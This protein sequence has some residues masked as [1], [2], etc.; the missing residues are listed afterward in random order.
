MTLNATSTV[1]ATVCATSTVCV[2]VNGG[3]GGVFWTARGLSNAMLTSTVCASAATTALIVMR[4]VV[5]LVPVVA[6]GLA[7][8]TRGNEKAMGGSA[9]S[10]KG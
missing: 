8:C 1:C 10:S 5:A 3:A 4:A 7:S 2:N 9:K 6:T